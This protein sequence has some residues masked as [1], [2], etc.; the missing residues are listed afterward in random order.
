L[1]L[2]VATVGT[3]SVRRLQ[4]DWPWIGLG[5]KYDFAVQSRV[6]THTTPFIALGAVML[7][8][9]VAIARLPELF[10][11]QL[12]R[13]SPLSQAQTGWAFR[14]L[15][16]AAIAQA[17]YGGFSVLQIDK[18]RESWK[19]D[20]KMA[21]MTRAEVAALVARNAAIMVGLTLVYGL[22]L[23][24]LTGERGSFWLFALLALL[25]TAWYYRQTRQ[26]TEYLAVQPEDE[27][28]KSNGRW[29]RE[30][31]DYCPPLARSLGSPD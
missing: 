8:V 30:P 22:A 19:A 29:E 14:L 31:D 21:D 4:P 26:I 28:T 10:V 18:V 27:T 15:A 17:A 20:P 24:F 7:I 9:F 23:F 13:S 12:E 6:E 16:V 1:T 25:Q 2:A 3:G 5:A 11:A